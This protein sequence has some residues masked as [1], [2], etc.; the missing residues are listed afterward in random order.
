MG[1]QASR[2]GKS[3]IIFHPAKVAGEPNKPVQICVFSLWT[4]DGQLHFLNTITTP[5]F[6]SNYRV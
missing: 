5:K 3:W 2:E 4:H 1:E 6:P